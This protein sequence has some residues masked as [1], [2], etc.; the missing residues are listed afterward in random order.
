[1]GNKV[2]NMMEVSADPLGTSFLV[3][4]F[5][6]LELTTGT[7]PDFRQPS[8]VEPTKSV[9]FFRD[10]QTRFLKRYC[11]YQETV[12]VVKHET[13][14]FWHCSRKLASA[15]QLIALISDVHRS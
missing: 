7:H 3:V 12:Q 5:E 2:A 9:F 13:R 11:Q 15:F 8:L 4:P 6:T 10:S 1:M 14:L